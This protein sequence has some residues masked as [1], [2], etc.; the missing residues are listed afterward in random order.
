MCKVI[1][2]T[3]AW[4]TCQL[5]EIRVLF[6]DIYLTNYGQVSFDVIGI[7]H[8]YILVSFVGLYW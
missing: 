2:F 3:K 5:N 7:F 8:S 6:C 1:D 4:E